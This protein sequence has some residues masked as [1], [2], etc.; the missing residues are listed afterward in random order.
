[1]KGRLLVDYIMSGGIAGIT[2]KVSVYETGY[3]EGTGI[4]M[5]D[6]DKLE[7]LLDFIEDKGFFSMDSE[8][9]SD[10]AVFDG[11]NYELTCKFRGKSHKVVTET[12]GKAPKEFYE[13]AK[14]LEHI[15]LT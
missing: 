4:F 6:Y 14:K 1:M 7:E 9:K 8:Y 12:G 2:N 10:S 13:I 3:V 11:F 5:R 15:L